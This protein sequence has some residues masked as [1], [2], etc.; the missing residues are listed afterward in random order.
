MEDLEQDLQGM[1][2]CQPRLL[3]G[4]HA[5]HVCGCFACFA[6]LHGQLCP[7][8]GGAAGITVGSQCI[9]ASQYGHVLR[10]VE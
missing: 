5:G 6:I 7:T 1:C 3:A 9:S 4:K 10:L 2:R 8:E